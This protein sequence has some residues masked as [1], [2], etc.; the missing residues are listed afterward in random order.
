MKKI[1]NRLKSQKELREMNA[2]KDKLFSI[3]AH[4][5]KSHFLELIGL[6]NLILEEFD[7]LSKNEIKTFVMGINESTK[8]MFNL[9]ENIFRIDFNLTTLCTY[10][11]R[12]IIGLVLCKEMVEKNVGHITVNSQ[13]NIGTTFYFTLPLWEGSLL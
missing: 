9:I 1:S 6:S 12:T 5:L 7:E 10:E 4:D 2:G 13:L 11:K 8:N 3:F